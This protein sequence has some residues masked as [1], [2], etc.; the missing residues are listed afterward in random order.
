MCDNPTGL[1][2]EG[3]RIRAA[4]PTRKGREFSLASGTFASTPQVNL[5]LVVTSPQL[6]LRMI[7]GPVQL[8][9]AGAAQGASYAALGYLVLHDT[10]IWAPNLAGLTANIICLAL[11]GLYGSP[12]AKSGKQLRD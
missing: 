4:G 8:T 11:I 6:F 3:W 10:N 1:T 9:I 5:D 7:V 2:D 12:N